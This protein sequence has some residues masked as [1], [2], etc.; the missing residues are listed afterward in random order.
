MEALAK[1]PGRY[2]VRWERGGGQEQSAFH[3]F[4]ALTKRKELRI[5]DY[6]IAQT[7]SSKY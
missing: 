4:G 6:V 3:M 2:S 1:G 7:Q 5:G